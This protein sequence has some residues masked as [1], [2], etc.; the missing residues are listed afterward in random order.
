[1]LR[2]SPSVPS[3]S[4]LAALA[5]AGGLIVS[6]AL[7]QDETS[8]PAAQVEMVG[9]VLLRDDQLSQVLDLIE[10]W[11]GRVI[12]RPASLPPGTYTLSLDQPLPK[13][14]ALRAL[15][16]LLNMNGVGLSPLGERFLKVAPLN[17]IRTEAPEFI[18]GST[19]NMPPSGRVVA[20]LFTL[21]FLRAAEFVPLF[22]KWGQ[23]E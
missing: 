17:L 23:A 7:A 1:M 10:R 18:D 15:E 14:E 20:K 13:T 11:T 4:T 6:P 3:R 12:L 21:D 9:P 22:R 19:L 2:L 8:R 16:T 5:L